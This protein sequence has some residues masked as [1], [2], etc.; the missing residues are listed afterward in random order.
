MYMQRCIKHLD[1]SLQ[2]PPHLLL[3]HVSC[4]VTISFQVVPSKST[5]LNVFFLD[6]CRQVRDI[7]NNAAPTPVYLPMPGA[8]TIV[9]YAASQNSKA[10]EDPRRGSIFL[11]HLLDYLPREEDIGS[12]IGAV[13]V[14][15]G[16]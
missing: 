4:P 15:I 3:A 5:A 6:I 2:V 10:Y 16:G 7:S 1:F 12:V 8:N 9:A 14:Q 13:Q 11:K